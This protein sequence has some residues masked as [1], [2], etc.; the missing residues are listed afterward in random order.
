VTIL[1]GYTHIAELKGRLCPCKDP[2]N[3]AMLEKREDGY[4]LI[5]W[6]GRSSKVTFDCDQERDEFIARY[7]HGHV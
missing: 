4:Y 3:Y 5:C 2:G 7:K 6:C 1:F